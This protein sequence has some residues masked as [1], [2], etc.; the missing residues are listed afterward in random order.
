MTHGTYYALKRQEEAAD[1]LSSVSRS[2]RILWSHGCPTAPGVSRY[3]L[4]PILL[5]Q[6]AP[7][8]LAGLSARRKP[9]P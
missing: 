3:D 9:A 7:K 4:E 5:A 8:A 1:R 2:G 6:T